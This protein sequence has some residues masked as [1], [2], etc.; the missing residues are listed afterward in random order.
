MAEVKKS[1]TVHFPLKYL[2]VL[3]GKLGE[4]DNTTEQMLRLWAFF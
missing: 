4:A 2:K 1:P 3:N